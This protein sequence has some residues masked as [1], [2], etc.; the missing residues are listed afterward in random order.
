MIIRIPVINKNNLFAP[1]LL[2]FILNIAYVFAN[3]K[4]KDSISSVNQILSIVIGIILVKIFTLTFGNLELTFKSKKWVYLLV[5]TVL[6]GT[7]IL[8][9]WLAFKSTT[10]TTYPEEVF[11]FLGIAV[12]LFFIQ[13][14][15]A[16]IKEMLYFGVFTIIAYFGTYLALFNQVPNVWENRVMENNFMFLIGWLFVLIEFILLIFVTRKFV[17]R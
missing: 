2:L 10:Q 9:V 4:V 17:T 1:S 11:K 15:F 12:L 3:T 6:A 5:N 8:L 7:Q 16:K 14:F 13:S